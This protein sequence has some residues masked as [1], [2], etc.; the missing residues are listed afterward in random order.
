MKQALEWLK[1]YSKSSQDLFSNTGMERLAEAWAT[2]I[3]MRP[4]TTRDLAGI[5][6]S[7]INLIYMLRTSAADNLVRDLTM[8]TIANPRILGRPI[9]LR[10]AEEGTSGRTLDLGGTASLSTSSIRS[11]NMAILQTKILSNMDSRLGSK[12]ECKERTLLTIVICT[13]TGRTTRNSS[14]SLS[15]LSNGRE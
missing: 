9:T 11:S 4:I 15:L 14:T 13:S 10:I 8:T 1:G 3:V 6:A 7:S 5:K 12:T 2:R